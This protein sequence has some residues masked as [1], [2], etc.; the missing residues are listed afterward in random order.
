MQPDVQLAKQE[1]KAWEDLCVMLV[2][3]DAVTVED[4]KR[5]CRDMSTPGCRLLETIRQWGKLRCD[6]AVQTGG[7][8]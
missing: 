6:L 5:S 7:R 2:A 3:S 8:M 1:H 4:L